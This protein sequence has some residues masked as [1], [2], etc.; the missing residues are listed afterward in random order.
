MAEIKLYKKFV[1]PICSWKL[2]KAPPSRTFFLDSVSLRAFKSNYR[3]CQEREIPHGIYE[4]SCDIKE[5]G[6][7]QNSSCT[8][9]RTKDGL[10]YIRTTLF[11]I[12]KAVSEGYVNVQGTELKMYGYFI[13]QGEQIYFVLADKNVEDSYCY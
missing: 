11:D 2:V 8:C 9:I 10:V 5:L 7:N 4:I 6:S 12:T 13:K 3:N 1:Q